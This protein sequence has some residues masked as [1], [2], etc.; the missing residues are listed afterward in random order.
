MKDPWQV[1]AFDWRDPV[2]L[3]PVAQGVWRAEE[4]PGQTLE[5][6]R[7]GSS[8]C[9]AIGPSPMARERLRKAV[10][11]LTLEKLILKEAAAGNF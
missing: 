4:R 1:I 10:S 3:L 6:S 9:G 2:H 8:H 5:G 11:E 7:E